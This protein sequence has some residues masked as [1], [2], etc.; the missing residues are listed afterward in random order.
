MPRRNRRTEM[1]P[2]PASRHQ[3][4]EAPIF[5]ITSHIDG[6]QGPEFVTTDSRTAFKV[7]AC[8]EAKGAEVFIE[9][10]KRPVNA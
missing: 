1:K 2:R 3:P 9:K 7:S 5:V 10:R 8:R 4:A 6:R